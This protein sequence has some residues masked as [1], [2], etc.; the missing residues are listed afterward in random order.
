MRLV[1][2]AERKLYTQS[3]LHSNIESDMTNHSTIE[4]SMI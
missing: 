3:M 1:F 2:L 4:L